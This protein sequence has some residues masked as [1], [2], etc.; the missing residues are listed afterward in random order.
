VEAGPRLGGKIQTASDGLETGAE[1]FLMRD[2][3]TGGPRAAAR[4][5]AALGLGDQLVHPATGASGLWVGGRLRALP[6][7]TI[8][9]VPGPSADL[10]GIATLVERDTDAG[11]PVLRPE[12]DVAVG[13]LVRERLGDEVVDHLVDPLLGGVYAGRADLLSLRTTMPGLAQALTTHHTL[14]DAVAAATASS[15]AHAATGLAP[16]TAPPAVFGTLRG[17]LSSLV[18][19]LTRRLLELGVAVH[20]GSPLRDLA[21]LPADA[22]VLACP[23]KPAARLLTHRSAQA[24]DLVGA[25]DYASVGL[26]TLRLPMVDLP[27]ITGFLVPADQGLAIKAATFFSRKWAHLAGAGETAVRVSIGRYGDTETLAHTDDALIELVQAD[28]AK[29][30][31]PLPPATSARVT[32]WGGGLPQYAPGHADRFATARALLAGSAV[33]LAGAAVD[34]VGIPACITSGEKAAADLGEF[35]S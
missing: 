18:E 17:G 12:E 22:Y 14:R 7:G 3:A 1:Q 20:C 8:M 24:A 19:A 35:I 25:L 9:G 31:G 16:D 11:P 15:R 26:V 28:L 13:A 21:D 23:A 27:E 5:V 10:D 34:G 30:L 4:L 2:G 33:V 6:T 29:V 32:R